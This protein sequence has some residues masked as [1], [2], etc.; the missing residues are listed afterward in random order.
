M[1]LFLLREITLGD[2]LLNVLDIYDLDK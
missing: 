2:M 1:P